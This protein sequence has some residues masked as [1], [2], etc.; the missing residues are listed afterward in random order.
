M[1]QDRQSTQTIQGSKL[2]RIIICSNIYDKENERKIS[3]TN[4]GVTLHSS[5]DAQTRNYLIMRAT[6]PSD[7]IFEPP[8]KS[9]HKHSG[10]FIYFWGQN[11]R[12][13]HTAERVALAAYLK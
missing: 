13:Q 2:L 5:K 8:V 1:F 4:K 7:I 12:K 3:R 10:V 11:Q 9:C 6:L